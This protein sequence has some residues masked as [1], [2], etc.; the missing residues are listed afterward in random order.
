[1]DNVELIINFTDIKR[2]YKKIFTTYIRIN[3]ST[4]IKNNNWKSRKISNNLM[5]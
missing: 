3:K 4:H 1:M 2:N 5:F